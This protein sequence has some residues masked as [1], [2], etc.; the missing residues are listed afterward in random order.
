MNKEKIFAELTEIFRTTFD[1]DDIV[2]T[3]A[4]TADDIEQWDSLNHINVLVAMEFRFGIKF[5][6]AEIDE[7]KNVGDLVDI[8]AAKLAR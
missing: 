2:L 4:T 6:I 3:R 1:R 8:I 7:L 5:Q